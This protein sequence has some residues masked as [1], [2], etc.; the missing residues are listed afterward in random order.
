M[1]KFSIEYP[2]YLYE[3]LEDKVKEKLSEN[4]SA[5]KGGILELVEN[6]VQDT[7]E[8]INVQNFISDYIK[9]P[10]STNLN[11]FV[12]DNDIFDFY[13]KYQVDIDQLCVDNGYFDDIPK[14]KNVFSLYNF[15]IEGTKFAVIE[16]MKIIQEE[17]F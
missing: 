1:K 5:L 13:L 9:E 17:V 15:V 4:Y 8:L 10:D 3:A 2:H 12:E 16:G 11:N 14:N 7:T 6:S